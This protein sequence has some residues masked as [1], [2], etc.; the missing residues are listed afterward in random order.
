MFPNYMKHN[1]AKGSHY[2]WSYLCTSTSRIIQRFKMMQRCGV[3]QSDWV[4]GRAWSIPVV[5]LAPP[6]GV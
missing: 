1:I 2:N 3:P 5:P 6:V 4:S